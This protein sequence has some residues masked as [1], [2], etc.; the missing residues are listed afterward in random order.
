MAAAMGC[1]PHAK[2][3]WLQPSAWG[4][5]PM[6]F[7][8]KRFHDEAVFMS[9]PEVIKPGFDE[10]GRSGLHH[11]ITSALPFAAKADVRFE[12]MGGVMVVSLAAVT[13]LLMRLL[14]A[15]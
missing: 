9:A 3:E 8:R 14:L 5:H 2:F 13:L 12:I 1:F 4:E 7:S 10:E 6:A 11:F 15:D